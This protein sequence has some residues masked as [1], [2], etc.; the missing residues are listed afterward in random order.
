MLESGSIQGKRIPFISG[1]QEL[2]SSIRV[3]LARE[4]YPLF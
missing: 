4:F 1:I 2:V 3:F